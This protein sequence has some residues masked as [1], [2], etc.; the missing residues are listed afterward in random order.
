MS[1]ISQTLSKSPSPVQVFR[2]R[3]GVQSL[4]T[5]GK[6]FPRQ[7]CQASVISSLKLLLIVG[8]IIVGVGAC[9]LVV[10]LLVVP[11]LGQTVAVAE[12]GAS[13]KLQ[14]AVSLFSLQTAYDGQSHLACQIG[15]FAVCLLTAPPSWVAEDIDVRSPE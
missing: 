12:D 13:I 6:P 11:M 8:F 1:L 9:G 7:T 15:V 3:A 5:T 10:Y 2:S 4:K 14:V